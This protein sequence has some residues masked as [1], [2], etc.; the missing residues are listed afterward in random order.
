[1]IFDPLDIRKIFSFYRNSLF[2]ISNDIHLWGVML[3]AMIPE[4]RA[5]YEDLFL[6]ESSFNVYNIPHDSLNGRLKTYH[7]TFKVSVDE[8]PDYQAKFFDRI[9][10]LSILRAYNSCELLLLRSIHLAYFPN[11]DNPLKTK[12]GADNIHREVKKS[13]SN[14]D[15]TNN[16]HIIQFLSDRSTEFNSFSKRVIRIDLKTDWANFFEMF[17]ILRNVIAHNESIIHVDTLNELKSKA[18]DIFERHFELRSDKDGFN[19]LHPKKGDAFKNFLNVVNDFSLNA[20][21]FI[22]HENDLLFL[23]MD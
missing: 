9:T 7:E 5:K 14:A 12:K 1:M 16:R 10:T 3:D 20:A 23:E 13:L 21:K 19:Y 15:T 11:L 4:Y 8:L 6:F 18:K 22:F 2:A 17:S